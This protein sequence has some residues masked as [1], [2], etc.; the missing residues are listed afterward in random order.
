[1]CI[2]NLNFTFTLKGTGAALSETEA[3]VEELLAEMG[4]DS[5]EMV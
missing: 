2:I 3:L 5:S 1:M 4:Q